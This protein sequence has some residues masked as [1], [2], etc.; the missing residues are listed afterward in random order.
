MGAGRGSP[1]SRRVRGSKVGD[2][3]EGRSLLEDGAEY[4]LFSAV[5]RSSFIFRYK[6]EKMTANLT[7]DD[8]SRFR[9]DYEELKGRF[10]EWTA[11]Q[12]LAQL[13]D[14]GGYSW[15]AQEDQ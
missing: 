5:D 13:W 15:L 14:Q 8:A 4:E 6:S 2:L 10:P 7:G 12:L 1:G 3:D 9:G 11:D